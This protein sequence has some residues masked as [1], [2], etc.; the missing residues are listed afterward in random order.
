[1]DKLIVSWK[2]S[3]YIYSHLLY[4]VHTHNR[5]L[6]APNGQL[7]QEGDMLKQPQLADTLHQ[8]AEQ[9]I[10]YFYNSSFTKMMV[11]ELQR[12]YGSIITLED[13]QNYS[14]VERTVATAKY[15][16]Q[17]M[18]GVSP[19]AGGAVLGL[20]LNI[21]DGEEWVW[22]SVP[23]YNYRDVYYLE[24]WVLIEGVSLCAH[25]WVVLYNIIM[26]LV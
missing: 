19:P 14:S 3:P 7:L 24:F 15:K 16:R 10:S 25:E 6:V 4:F 26:C 8:I 22:Y 2:Y 18:V 1:M 17:G 9:G 21:L 12:D 20:I 11:K 13:F 5:D 23:C